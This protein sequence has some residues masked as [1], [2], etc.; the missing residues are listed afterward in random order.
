[1]RYVNLLII[2]IFSIFIVFFFNK[3]ENYVEEYNLKIQKLDEKID[4]LHN[5]NSDLFLKIDTLN[6]QILG[7][8]QELNL[9][10]NSINTL[11]NEV[12]EKASNVDRYTDDELQEF[13][14]NRYRY[15]FDSLRK[16]NSTSSN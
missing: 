3:K 12:N 15:Y 11:K 5:V 6:T 9:K 16:T 10:D 1:V 4:S 8:D 13:F 7:L 2:I 14:T